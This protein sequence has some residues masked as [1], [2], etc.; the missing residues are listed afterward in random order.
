MCALNF[1]DSIFTTCPTNNCAY[2]LLHHI[3]RQPNVNI[4]HCGLIYSRRFKM[5]RVRRLKRFVYIPKHNPAVDTWHT[6]MSPHSKGYS[7]DC[8]INLTQLKQV[9]F[10]AVVT[11]VTP[12]YCKSNLI[13]LKII[14]FQA[15]GA[16]ICTNLYLI[17]H[18]QPSMK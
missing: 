9:L 10:S 12:Y 13:K 4:F 17:R 16:L 3:I 18:N 15:R 6:K 1:S 2:S 8:F 5:S 14:L 7:G 11:T